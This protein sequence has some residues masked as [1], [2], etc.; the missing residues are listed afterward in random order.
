[1]AIFVEA[2]PN[3]VTDMRFS[4]LVFLAAIAS[5]PLS[6]SAQDDV[7]DTLDWHG[8]FPLGTEQQ[9]RYARIGGEEIG[10]KMT[11]A[12]AEATN[13]LPLE[14]GDTWTY[15]TV[16]DP[17]NAPLDT[18]WRGT[19]S[20]SESVVRDSNVYHV[21]GFPFALA[22]TLRT[23]AIG[24]IWSY[25]GGREILFLDFTLDEGAGYRFPDLWGTRDSFEVS[26][27]RNVTVEVGAGRFQNCVR[28]FFDHP[29][30]DADRLYAFAPGVGVVYAYGML[31]DYAEL[32]SAVVGGQVI[33]SVESSDR[34]PAEQLLHVYP[35]PLSDRGVVTFTTHGPADVKVELFDLLG[36]RVREVV[37]GWYNAGRHAETV[38]VS[39]L[40]AGVY[41]VRLRA[42]ESGATRSLVVAR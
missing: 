30:L 25:S 22:D 38:D 3:R 42:E 9:L 13:Y 26:V 27:E 14:V 17:P 39:A 1:M 40:P 31:G 33:S 20:V 19:F 16:L 8:Y 10:T 15:M 4:A 24:R 29:A 5:G 37:N 23:D 35:Y 36:R 6:V 18:V 7:P 32:H 34:S 11:F 41:F 2:R 12:V 28:V 21:T